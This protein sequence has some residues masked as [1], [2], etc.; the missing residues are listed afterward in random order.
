MAVFVRLG[1]DLTGVLVDERLECACS[2][3][4]DNLLLLKKLKSLRFLYFPAVALLDKILEVTV[5]LIRS[6]CLRPEGGIVAFWVLLD[7]LFYDDRCS[8]AL[9]ELTLAKNLLVPF[10]DWNVGE[11]LVRGAGLFGLD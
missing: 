2:P 5:G 6:A 3:L 8:L 11:R 9:L 10:I 4:V 7:C 1:D